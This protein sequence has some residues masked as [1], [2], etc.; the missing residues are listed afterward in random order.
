[1]KNLMA[2][3]GFCQGKTN[4][5]KPNYNFIQSALNVQWWMVA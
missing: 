1:M 4:P 5:N 2:L 3:G